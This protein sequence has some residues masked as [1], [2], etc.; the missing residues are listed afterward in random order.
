MELEF[1]HSTYSKT[2]GPL[3]FLSLSVTYYIKTLHSPLITKR[4][5]TI[6]STRE[7]LNK[8]NVVALPSPSPWKQP[9][10]PSPR[11]SP[12]RASSSTSPSS[13]TR[14]LPPPLLLLLPLMLLLRRRATEASTPH[15][16]A[17][18]LLPS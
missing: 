10:L 16:F 2:K 3:L 5:F 17:L 1:Y 9:P 13:T 8:V 7:E 11:S 12:R 6:Q 14:A 18:L 15:P 4:P